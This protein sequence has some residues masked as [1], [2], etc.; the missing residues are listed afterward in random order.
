MTEQV[1]T[2]GTRLG[3]YEI[4]ALIGQGGMGEVYR[5]RD[6]KLDRDVA[7]KI[8]P[9]G[10]ATDP[11]R[12]ARFEREA[13]TLAS[14]NHPNIAHIHGAED[15]GSTRA[16][17]MEL[18]EGEDLSQRIARGPMALAEAL[19]IAR[20][21]AEAMQT[22][23][24]HGIIHRD[25]KPAN[26]KVK[27]DGT[28][29]I[30]DFGLAKAA[31]A[32]PVDDSLSHSPTMMATMPGTL[33]GTAAYMS[34]EQVKGQTADARS[35]VWAFGCLLFEMLTG[36]PAFA[37]ATRSEILASVL[38]TE[39]DWRHLP[40]DTPE[41]VRRLLRRCL[42]KNETNRLRSIADARLEIDDAQQPDRDPAHSR[43][44][45]RS[46]TER[47]AWASLVALLGV[48]ALAWGVW[49]SRRLPAPP[50]VRFDIATPEVADPFLLPSVALSADGRQILF[51]AD[52]DGQPHVWL[53]AIDSVSARPLA[54]TGGAAF[55]FWSPDG[56]SVAFY[57]DGFLK[58]LDLDGGLVRTLAKATVGV[59]GTWSRDGVILFVRNPASA[60]V[61]VSA[62]GGPVVDATRLDA[63]QVGHS[64]PHFLPDG[65]HFLYYVAAAPDSRGIHV[66]QLDGSSSRRLVDADAGGVYTNGHLLFI[67]QT[68]VYA[69]AFDA[70]RLELRGNPFQIADGVYSSAGW[71]SV[72]L[73]A[74]PAAFA[75]RTGAARFARQF[76]WVDRSGNQIATVGDRLG[77]PDG[78]SYSPDR[79]QLV[80][81]E[82]G[83]A[84]SDLWMLDTRRG[85]V[86]R[87]TDDAD[88]DIF[89]L[90]ARDTNRI[91][92]TAVRNG[93]CSIYQRH[94][95][96]GRK[97]LLIP[98]QTEETFTCDT[99]PDGRSL[100]YQRMNA[101]T[102]WD[103]WALPL[104]GDGK[105]VPVVQTD[106]DERTARLS[107]DGRWVAFVA[108]TSGVFEVYVQPFPGPG[109]RLQVSTRGG[110]QPQWRADGAELFYIALDGKLTATSI[111]PAADHQSIDV[112]PPL[113]LFVAQVG[114]VG[115]HGA[116]YAPSVDGQRFL[117]NRLLRDAG[118]TPLR[119]V[120]NWGAGR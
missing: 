29:K 57:A 30:L 65:K 102:G 3:P 101:K 85:L 28:V 4:K 90:W 112:G 42:E 21:I 40:P 87:F 22:A 77:N 27:A 25:L 16:L 91:I 109:R 34:P 12:L 35:D 80:F 59:G 63:G 18:V 66:G 81:F 58:R 39:P 78:V 79:S 67:R 55:P 86:S 119:V 89:P 104:G 33:L 6:T 61:R 74:G 62:E 31:D 75:F 100:V 13:K 83:A 26:V 82:R 88:E 47:L 108:N 5:A 8:L 17:V 103:I 118:G 54:G 1:L 92:Y 41:S 106:A 93:Q 19:A 7:I 94:T 50:E 95:G 10:F 24:D 23:H 72:T 60:I 69:Q 120:L 9:A 46:R 64:F 115:V 53:R 117:V 97:E 45:P 113:P 37:A 43:T 73:S 98:P 44:A 99:S 114:F 71:H 2:P 105:P 11:D 51:V 15:A 96:T 107:P 56:R 68:N 32:Q 110:D 36:R 48:A 70:E 111:K 14:L 76:T 49:S 52:S 38:T 84:S 116:N 20:Q